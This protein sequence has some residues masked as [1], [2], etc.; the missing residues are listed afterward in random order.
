MENTI[1]F[2]QSGDIARLVLNNPARHNALGQQEIAQIASALASLAPDTR[3]LVIQ[4]GG[5]STFCSGAALDQITSGQLSGDQFQAMTNSIAALPIPTVCCLNGNVF[6]GGVELAMSCDFRIG[7]T[8][9]VM[10]VPAAAIGLCYPIDGIDRLI[11]RLGINA[12]KRI[13]VAAEELTSEEMLSLGIIGDIAP[14]ELIL[15]VTS[16]MA[17]A[18]ARLAPLAVHAMLN[19]FAQAEAGGIDRVR[20]FELAERCASSEDLQEGLLAK[21]ERRPP[22]FRG[23]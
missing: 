22:Q 19:I 20:A 9:A 10:R 16:D 11:S 15:D 13:L 8:G 3:V 7:V 1:E 17:A 23:R 18:L 2:T 6:G 14:R 4:S 21:K 12:A 5:G